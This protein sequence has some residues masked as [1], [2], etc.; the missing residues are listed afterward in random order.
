MGGVEVAVLEDE[1]EFV[2]CSVEF[3]VWGTL[4]LKLFSF[5]LNI[6]VGMDRKA[7]KMEFILTVN[8]FCKPV[9]LKYKISLI[10]EFIFYPTF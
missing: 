1:D 6:F 10:L 5:K 3:F 7:T 4:F 8:I 2:N 9:K